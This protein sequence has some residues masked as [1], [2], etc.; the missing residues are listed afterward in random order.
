MIVKGTGYSLLGR[1][2]FEALK[3][4]ICG[5]NQ[6]AEERPI[7]QQKLVERLQKYESV[8]SVEMPGHNGSP[9]DLELHSDASP[10]FMKARPIPFA[11][12]P[13][14]ERELDKL[15]QDIIIEP[16][17]HSYWATP[18]VALVP[19]L[20]VILSSIVKEWPSSMVPAIFISISR[21]DM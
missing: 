2:W 7:E 21:A 3:I 15:E 13:A 5:I 11:L 16:T 10:K 12:Q 19:Q 18:L 14:Y 9:V 20:A 17:Q 1:N 6:A 8:F 4:A